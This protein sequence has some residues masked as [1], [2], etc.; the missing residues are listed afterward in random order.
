MTRLLIAALCLALIACGGG[1]DATDAP[2]SPE[3]PRE[4]TNT[5]QPQSTATVAPAATERAT[6]AASVSIT[7]LMVAGSNPGGRASVTI[8]T[9]PIG[10]ECDISYTTPNGTLSEAEGLEP[11]VTRGSGTVSWEWTISTATEPGTGRVKV[12]CDGDSATSDIEI[13]P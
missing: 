13:E 2:E 4:P 6:A 3:T 8:R 12:T 11:A 5:V 1:D 10:V 7:F 9:D